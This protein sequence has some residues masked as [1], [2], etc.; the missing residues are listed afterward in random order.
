MEKDKVDIRDLVIVGWKFGDFYD[1]VVNIWF[2]LFWK[3]DFKLMEFEVLG[4]MVF[5]GFFFVVFIT[6]CKNN[7]FSLEIE[8]LYI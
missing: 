6:F 3:L 5:M 2:I 8:R 4:L 1:V 7:E